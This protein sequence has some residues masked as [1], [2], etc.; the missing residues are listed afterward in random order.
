MCC[1]KIRECRRE[2]CRCREAKFNSSWR[3]VFDRGLFAIFVHLCHWTGHCL[4][5]SV[6]D[7][8]ESGPESEL[9]PTTGIS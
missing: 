4:D 7:F 3:G 1:R 9:V 8:G 6:D 5:P 2:L